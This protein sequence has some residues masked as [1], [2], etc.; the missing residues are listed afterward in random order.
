MV[1]VPISFVTDHIETLCEIDIEYRHLAE[2][3]GVPNYWRVPAIGTDALY[4]EALTDMCLRVARE[5]GVYSFN[6]ERYCT[7]NFEKCPCA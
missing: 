6:K 5:K 1:V 4:I 2:E 7:R 3:H